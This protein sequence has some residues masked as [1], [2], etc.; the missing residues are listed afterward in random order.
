MSSG[1]DGGSCAAIWLTE[2]PCE[3]QRQAIFSRADRTFV[4]EEM[5]LGGF[6]LDKLL[7]SGFGDKK[8]IRCHNLH[9]LC[10]KRKSREGCG[11]KVAAHPIGCSQCS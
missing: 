11:F 10:I 6:I 3:S 2:R 4:K 1:E 5:L 9:Q 7:R 8:T